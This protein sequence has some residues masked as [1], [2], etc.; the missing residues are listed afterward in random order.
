MGVPTEDLDWWELNDSLKDVARQ[1]GFTRATW[2]DEDRG[3]GD[4]YER[5]DTFGLGI[6]GLFF[7]LIPLV[8]WLEHRKWKK[9]GVSSEERT[10]RLR[11]S[12]VWTV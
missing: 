7:L 2:D 1:L 10:R 11:P 5:H 3:G 12:F 8:V 6:G 4:W 9:T